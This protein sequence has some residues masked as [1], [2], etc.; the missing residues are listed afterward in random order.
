MR[1]L[2]PA[3]WNLSLIA[4]C[5]AV[6]ALGRYAISGWALQL[7]GARFAYGT[8]AVNVIGCFL[9]GLLAQVGVA[10]EAISPTFRTALGI[11]FLGA[12]TTFSTFGLETFY[13]LEESS[14]MLA[15]GNVAA[16]VFF[17]LAAVWGGL[18]VARWLVGGA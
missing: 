12:F 2:L 14:W 15:F 3:A 1:D 10:T 17:G 9:I 6:G 16:N 7:L 18:A 13:Y 8:L 5:G 11:G 4:F